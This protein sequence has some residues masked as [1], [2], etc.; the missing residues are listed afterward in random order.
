MLNVINAEPLKDK[1]A[2]LFRQDLGTCTKVEIQLR[3]QP[4]AQPVH[5]AYRPVALAVQELLNK[6]LD[7]LVRNGTISPVETSIWAAPIVVARRANGNI[8][9]CA[10]YSTGLNNALLSEDYPIPNMEEVLT[11]FSGNRVFSQL[12]FADAYHQLQLDEANK[13]L[14]TITTHRGLFRL[15]SQTGTG[16]F[17]TYNRVVFSRH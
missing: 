6:E 4:N 15:R 9:L 8:R 5:R 2:T 1:F 17:L 7:R 12:D 10:D 3:L 13:A 16:D 14:T 11:K